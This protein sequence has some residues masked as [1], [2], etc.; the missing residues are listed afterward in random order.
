MRQIPV[1]PKDDR[2][3]KPLSQ[4]DLG[5]CLNSWKFT[6]NVATVYSSSV[7]YSSFRNVSNK[8]ILSRHTWVHH[9]TI[10]LHNS[11]SRIIVLIQWNIL[12]HLD[13]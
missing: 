5:L 13:L 3:I 6:A 12:H 4:A 11:A 7:A 8:F 10:F 9:S 2:K 1:K